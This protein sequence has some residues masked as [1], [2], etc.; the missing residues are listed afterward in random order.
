MDSRNSIATLPF[1]RLG[2]FGTKEPLLHTNEHNQL[3]QNYLRSTLADLAAM[4]ILPGT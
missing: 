4:V 2:C 1:V 3:V